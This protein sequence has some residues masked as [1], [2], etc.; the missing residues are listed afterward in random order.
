MDEPLSSLDVKRKREILPHI[1]TLPEIFGVPILYV[2]HN[3][4]EVARLANDVVLLV[5][6]Q[7]RGARRRGGGFRAQRSRER[8]RAGSRLESSCAREV[9]EV[10]PRESQP[11]RVGNPAIAGAD[12]GRGGRRHSARSASMRATSRSRPS[13]PRS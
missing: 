4:D 2:T 1:E 9:I 8:S 5:D 3:L 10:R 11:L 7:N 13:A 6:G 12:G